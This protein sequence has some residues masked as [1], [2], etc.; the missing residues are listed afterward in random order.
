MCSSVVD[1][2]AISR[3]LAEFLAVGI[4]QVSRGALGQTVRY[5]PFCECELLQI[6]DVLETIPGWAWDGSWI[7]PV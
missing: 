3:G 6:L 2:S 1:R 7:V 5:S 4:R